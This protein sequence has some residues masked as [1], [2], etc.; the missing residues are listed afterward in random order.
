MKELTSERKEI[1]EILFARDLT[2]NELHLTSD[3]EAF[4]QKHSAEA[5]SQS[6]DE[7]S[8]DT[9]FRNSI[10]KVKAVLSLVKDALDKKKAGGFN[11]AFTAPVAPAVPAAPAAE[12]T[13]GEK[14]GDSQDDQGSGDQAPA[15]DNKPTAEELA[16][17]KKSLKAEYEQLAGKKAGNGVTVEWLQGK[18]AELKAAK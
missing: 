14:G 13:V 6:L 18:I 7:K 15:V 5:H 2:I 1:L 16:D 9:Y 12:N 10:E 11:T 3:N 17:L 4:R 8:V